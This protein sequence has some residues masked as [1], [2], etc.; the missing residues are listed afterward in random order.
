MTVL[1]SIYKQ[2]A[3]LVEEKLLIIP[4]LLLKYI[5]LIDRVLLSHR[6]SP[7]QLYVDPSGTLLTSIGNTRNSVPGAA[8]SPVCLCAF[9][10]AWRKHR[11]EAQWLSLYFGVGAVQ[12]CTPL[13]LP[14]N[15]QIYEHN[16]AALFMDHSGMLVMLPFDLRVSRDAAPLKNPLPDAPLQGRDVEEITNQSKSSV[17]VQ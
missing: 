16:E 12:L 9:W 7:A 10:V 11:P 2:L 3:Q 15:R 5:W 4:T 13:L 1:R 6:L 17:R 8:R 14:R